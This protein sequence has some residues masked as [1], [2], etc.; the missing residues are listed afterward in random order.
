MMKITKK[1]KAI[2]MNRMTEMKKTTQM[3]TTSKLTTKMV[4]IPTMTT[5]DKKAT[6]TMTEMFKMTIT[7]SFT[8]MNYSLAFTIC[9][10]CDG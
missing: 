4:K 8:K 3:T 7:A 2:E 6:R 5:K 9:E 1:R 10:V